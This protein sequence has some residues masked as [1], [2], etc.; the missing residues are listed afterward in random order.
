[1]VGVAIVTGGNKGI[2]FGICK[3]LSRKF[4]GDVYLTARSEERGKA[5]LADLKKQ[6]FK[7][8]FH[9]LDIDDPDSVKRLRDFM[10]EKYGGIDI[11][12]NNA[13]IFINTETSAEPIGVQ[14][15]KICRTN[16]WS[17][18]N[19]CDTLFPLLRSGA[20]VVNVSSAAGLLQRLPESEVKKKLK[21]SGK[22]LTVI[23]VNHIY[24]EVTMTAN[25]FL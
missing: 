18:K 17:T 6:G 25:V 14:A 10:K 24:V 19:V 9:Q 11:L 15:E 13:A 21:S 3:G 5:A 22:G 4:N 7:V 23:E 20:R 1:M 2:G 12:V 16:Y 8:H